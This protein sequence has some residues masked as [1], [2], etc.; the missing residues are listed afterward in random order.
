MSRKKN[1]KKFQLIE[2]TQTNPPSKEERKTD[3]ALV[4]APTRE[5]QMAG[6]LFADFLL[7]R[8]NITEP[9]ENSRISILPIMNE[10]AITSYKIVSKSNENVEIVVS[11]DTIS[12]SLGGKIVALDDDGVVYLA[13]NML[14]F[15]RNAL[16]EKTSA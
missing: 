13:T 6:M 10:N 9:V 7:K 14:T 2:P 12:A 15:I 8:L 1:K 3:L 11:S 4:N 5:Q 16:S